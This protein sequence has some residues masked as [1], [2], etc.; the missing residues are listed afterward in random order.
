MNKEFLNNKLSFKIVGDDELH[1]WEKGQI[2]YLVDKHLDFEDEYIDNDETTP[3][4]ERKGVI[5]STKK[6]KYNYE[7]HL[8]NIDSGEWNVLDQ[9][10][11]E[12]FQFFADFYI[13]GE[14]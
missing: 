6:K 8:M 13:D 14:K 11:F 3:I 4:I 2:W 7:Y 9:D 12:S 5:F 10:E 1:R